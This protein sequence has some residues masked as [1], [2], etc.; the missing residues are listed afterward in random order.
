MPMQP[1]KYVDNVNLNVLLVQ[2]HLVFHAKLDSHFPQEIVFLNAQAL[3]IIKT[4]LVSVV[5]FLVWTVMDLTMINVLHALHLEFYKNLNVC[6]NVQL[7]ISIIT[8]P[9]NAIFVPQKPP[10]VLL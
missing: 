10:H 1:S 4:K 9:E 5:T 7:D 3:L 8:L 6:T 2:I